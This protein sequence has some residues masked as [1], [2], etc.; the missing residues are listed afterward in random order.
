MEQ[1]VGGRV[2]GSGSAVGLPVPLTLLAELIPE[3][4]HPLPSG[5]S[6]PAIPRVGKCDKWILKTMGFWYS[7]RNWFSLTY[8]AVPCP[9]EAAVLSQLLHFGRA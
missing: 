5:L 7:S 1:N 9:S 8:W 3:Q 2:S 4:L 6:Q